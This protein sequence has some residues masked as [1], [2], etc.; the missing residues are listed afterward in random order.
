M[1]ERK[2][3]GPL[4]RTQDLVEQE[5]DGELL[6][7]DLR[8]HRAHCLNSTAAKVYQACDGT[9]TAAEI[10]TTL[11]E[12]LGHEVPQ[13]IVSIALVRL[14]EE[15]LLTSG[16]A[17]AAMP[18]REAIRNVGLMSA[19]LLPVISSIAAPLSVSAASCTPDGGSCN[20]GNPGACCSR[21]C[22]QPAGGAAFCCSFGGPFACPLAPSSGLTATAP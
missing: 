12:K 3:L 18:R 2:N 6:L 7:Y 16:N 15:G 17:S 5:L 8:S 1:L 13:E 9:R 14:H 20:L 22:T 4:G 11:S 10:R 21:T 19:I